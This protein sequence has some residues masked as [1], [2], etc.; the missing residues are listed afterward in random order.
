MEIDIDGLMEANKYLGD[1]CIDRH[2]N[3]G[4]KTNRQ[5]NKYPC[6]STSANLYQRNGNMYRCQKILLEHTQINKQTNR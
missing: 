1:E 3:G 2:L 6:V 4:R 5:D